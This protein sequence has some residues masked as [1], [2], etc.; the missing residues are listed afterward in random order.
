MYMRISLGC[1][2][3]ISQLY[4]SGFKSTG[5]FQTVRIYLCDFHARIARVAWAASEIL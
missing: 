5:R 1:R 2:Y 3:D 4:K